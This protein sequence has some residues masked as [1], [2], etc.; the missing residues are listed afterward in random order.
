MSADSAAA[1]PTA[2][3]SKTPAEVDSAPT[4]PA[5]KAPSPATPDRLQLRSSKS[6]SRLGQEV[7]SAADVTVDD[8]DMMD[9]D[10]VED[11]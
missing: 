1:R 5:K 9:V 6:A 4:T 3:E 10:S 2:P 8:E 7:V 11:A